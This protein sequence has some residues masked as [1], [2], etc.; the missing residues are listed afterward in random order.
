MK[1]TKMKSNRPKTSKIRQ[2]AKGEE[3]TLRFEGCLYTTETTVLCHSNL[4]ADGRGM[5]IKSPD[6]RAAYGCFHCHNILDGRSPRPYYFTEKEMLEKFE[7]GVLITHE[8][9]KIKLGFE[10]GN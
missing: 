1:R 10:N 8:R 7:L 5:G 2:S 4:L 6:L 9:L 3:C